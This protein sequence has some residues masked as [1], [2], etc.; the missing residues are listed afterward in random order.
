M[1]MKRE[2]GLRFFYQWE[3][4]Q[5][6]VVE[7]DC[8]IVHFGN[9]TTEKAL[10]CEVFEE[11]GVRKVKVPNIFLQTAADLHAYAWNENPTSVTEHAVFGVEARAKPADYAYTETEVKRYDVLLQMLEENAAYYTPQVDAEGNL[12][13]EKSLDEM[14]D[15]PETNLKVLLKKDWN[16]KDETKPDAILNRPGIENGTGLCSIVEGSGSTAEGENAHAEGQDTVASGKN[17]HAEG[18]ETRASGAHSHAEGNGTTASGVQAHAE[19]AYSSAS[20]NQAHAEGNSTAANGMQSHAEGYGTTAGGQASHAEGEYSTASGKAA[21]AEGSYT[22]ATFAYSHA[23]G[24]ST[25]ASEVAAHAEG[26]TT[27]ATAVAAHAEGVSTQALGYCSHAEGQGTKATFN[28]AHAEGMYTIAKGM[29]QHVQGKYNLE[30]ADASNINYYGKYAHIIG[31]GSDENAR[32][33]AFTVS[34]TGTA[35]AVN[36][37]ALGADYAEY[38]EWADGNAAAEDRVGF[39]VALDGEKIRFATADDDILGVISGTAAVLG[40]TAEWEWC[41]KYLYDDFGRVITE[42]VEVF[43][44]EKDL[45]TGEEKQVSLGFFDAPKINPDYDATQKYINR[46][47]RPEWAVVGMFGKL[48][49]RDDGTCQ[50]NGYACVGEAGILTAAAEKTNMRVLSRTADNIIRV[51]LK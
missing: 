36:H 20:A 49:V 37:G 11:D 3:Q 35:S 10:S 38:F 44:T 6:L 8:T 2:N 9:G 28:A 23:E 14:P 40:D 34:W 16:Q 12:S 15:L 27:K 51:L 30:D 22:Q 46:K 13:W 19:G 1:P 39:V 32:S 33:N 24:Q 26:R 29:A 31:N 17:A 4:N 50:I 48:F 7:T 45:E 43:D 42:S 41:K 25:I 21:H 5:Q 18:K 47:E